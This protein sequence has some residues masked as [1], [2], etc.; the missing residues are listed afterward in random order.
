MPSPYNRVIALQA[1][2][3]KELWHYELQGVN[4]STRGVEYWPGDSTSP[5]TI[6]FG[7]TDGHLVAL[8][9]KTGRLKPGFGNE[10]IVNMK[11]FRT[12]ISAFRRRRR[13]STT[14]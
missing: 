7:T 8:N 4:A 14:S 9:A 1:E 13:W 11:D 6:F 2:T 5:A 3:G 10:G 12:A